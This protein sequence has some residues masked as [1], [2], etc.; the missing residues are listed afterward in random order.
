MSRELLRASG[1]TI[2]DHINHDTLD[3]RRSNLRICTSTE[4]NR[5]VRSKGKSSRFKGVYWDGVNKKWVAVITCG[6]TMKIGL[7]DEEEDAAIMYNVAAQLF[8]GK[9]AYLNPV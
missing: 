5:N 1:S 9:F 8:F 4:N 2:V 7:L 6:K 3:N